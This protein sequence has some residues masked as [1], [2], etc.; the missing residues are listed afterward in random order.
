MVLFLIIANP[1]V[2]NIV[3]SIVGLEHNEDNRSNHKYYLLLIHSVV[4]AAIIFLILSIYNPFKSH[5]HIIPKT[6]LIHK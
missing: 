3:G 2:Y 1:K 4:Y 5:P 6:K